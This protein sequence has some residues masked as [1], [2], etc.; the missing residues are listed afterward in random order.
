MIQIKV[1]IQEADGVE[2]QVCVKYEFYRA[3]TDPEETGPTT[4]NV[5][6]PVLYI[7]DFYSSHNKSRDSSVV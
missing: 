4:F 5:Y 7:I 2:F 1:E 3:D 6:A